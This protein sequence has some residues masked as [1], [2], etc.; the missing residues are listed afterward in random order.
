MKKGRTRK[1]KKLSVPNV[2][3]PQRWKDKEFVSNP[4]QTK[5]LIEGGKCPWCKRLYVKATEAYYHRGPCLTEQAQRMA[6]SIYG[7]EVVNNNEPIPE[8]FWN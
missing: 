6:Q 4:T 7:P 1:S 5:F 2:N 3:F 8:N